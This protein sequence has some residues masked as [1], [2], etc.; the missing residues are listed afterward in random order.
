MSTQVT[1]EDSLGQFPDVSQEIIRT[2]L[3]L[4][5]TG[6]WTSTQKQM[7]KLHSP[8][9]SA[10]IL[11]PST[12]VNNKRVK[13]WINKI[14]RYCDP[15]DLFIEAQAIKGGRG[16][17]DPEFLRA[18]ATA[19]EKVKEEVRNTVLQDV[20][21]EVSKPE[22]TSLKRAMMEA[23]TQSREHSAVMD[24][25]A[26]IPTEQQVPAQ[27]EE[28]YVVSSVPWLAKAGPSGV[29][30]GSKYESPHTLEEL[31]SDGSIRYKCRTCD[32]TDDNGKSVSL[33]SGRKHGANR[34]RERIIV[35][36]YGPV[37]HRPA[38]EPRLVS[39]ILGA[40]DAI[41]NWHLLSKEIL[42]ER[43]STLI[44]EARPDRTPSEPLTPEQVIERIRYLVDGERIGAMHAEVEQLRGQYAEVVARAEAAEAAEA[45]AKA[46][47]ERVRVNLRALDSM[48]KD[49]VGD[50]Q[51]TEEA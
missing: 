22:P 5:W 32:F 1:L 38:R 42:A 23:I 39:D 4:K 43:V 37:E 36:D 7:V 15:A 11:V 49:I 12:N 27:D 9:G 10:E 45:A 31:M 25:G 26:P 21:D 16:K 6:Y 2:A 40:L 35:N 50:D 8:S 24:E 3:R 51:G 44:I 30:K 48:M 14:A 29:G 18:V 20:E 28:P 19:A 41:E 33:H 13:A 47:T 34:E 46:E 17:A